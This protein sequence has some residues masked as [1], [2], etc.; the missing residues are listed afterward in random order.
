MQNFTFYLPTK[1]IFGAG[2]INQVG[3]ES[4]TLGKRALIVTGKRSASAFGIINRVTDYLEKEGVEAVVFDKIE[5]NPRTTTID[6]AGRLARTN[7]CDFVIGL[8]GG[9]PMDAAKAIAAAA[10]EA[11]PI[12][13]FIPHG[14]GPVKTVKK[15]LPILEIPTLAA[16]GSE[17]DAGGVFT[18]WET[19]EKAVLFSPL[20]FP[21]VSII[22]PELTITVPK[23]YTI[24]GG[25]DIICHVIEGFFTGADN[26]PIQDR[27][28]LSIIRTVMENL[29]KV[30][31]NP[32]DVEARANLS[33]ASA[34][35]LSGMV[36]SGRGG[37][38]PIHA[39]EHSLSGHYDISHGLGL[40]LLL[41]AIMEYG[42]KARP[43]K[44][45]MLAQELFDI[46]RDGQTDEQLA[47]KAIEEM[48][49]FL[50]SA[51]RLL[52]LK[53]IGIENDSKLT[54]MA[55]DALKIYGVDGQYLANPKKLYKDDILAIFA[56]LATQGA[57]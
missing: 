40:A 53:D 39:L 30:V 9:S 29:P 37:S 42:Y 25:I 7:N 34:V 26:T 19:H 41:P 57:S 32:K 22:D 44:Y 5:P 14:T 18:N 21:R 12:W 36:N 31:E 23:D 8:G 3:I 13:E 38:Y 49:K 56:K 2:A 48:K 52:S 50:K 10:V 24:D 4:A 54:K 43:S 11:K 46:H 35:A 47:E 20:L 6:E 33:W 17:A 16:T 15:A 45:A 27:F 51:G 55:D 28:A 1:I